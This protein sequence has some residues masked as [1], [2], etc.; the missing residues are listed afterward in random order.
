MVY[1]LRY[2]Y[3]L[4][5]RC[6]APAIAGL[7]GALQGM[8]KARLTSVQLQEGMRQP[9]FR[10]ANEAKPVLQAAVSLQFA[11]YSPDNSLPMSHEFS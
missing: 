6:S 10:L 1:H 2:I 4:Y 8:A 3:I 9:E 5:Y 7:A 11:Y